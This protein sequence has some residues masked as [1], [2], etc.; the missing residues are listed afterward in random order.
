MSRRPASSTPPSA[1]S[2]PTCSGRCVSSPPSSSTCRHGRMPRSSRSRRDSPTR[3]CGSR[4]A[5]TPR[6]RSSTSHREH[7]P[8]AR[9]YL[10]AGH[11]ARAARSS[12]RAH[13]RRFA[14]R[15]V[16]PARRFTSTRPCHSWPASRTRHRDPRRA[17]QAAALLGGERGLRAGDRDG[18]FALTGAKARGSGLERS[19][20]SAVPSSADH[21]ARNATGSEAITAYL[22][23]RRVRRAR[24]TAARSRSKEA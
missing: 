7:P 24:S 11:R 4:G 15:G 3:R 1:R 2:T 23:P 9:R 18:E 17:R 6:R 8:A 16:P 5:T 14:H 12:H 21:A 10:G 20:R 22:H 13:A 19:H